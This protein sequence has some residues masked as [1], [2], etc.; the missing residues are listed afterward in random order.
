MNKSKPTAGNALIFNHVALLVKDVD[1][2]VAFYQRVFN[3][4]EIKNLTGKDGIRWLSFDDGGE[5][6]LISLYDAEI[7]LHKSVHFCMATSDFD[8][9]VKSL[10]AKEISYTD[11]PGNTNQI[12]YRAD[13]IKQ[14]YI[15]DPDGYWI[16]INNVGE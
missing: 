15:Q 8:N 14:V 7:K 6:H 11:W 10:K 1:R 12:N 13:G 9:F 5:I 4:K 3:L 16:E 2:S